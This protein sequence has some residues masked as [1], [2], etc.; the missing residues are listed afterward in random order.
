[1]AYGSYLRYGGP[2]EVRGVNAEKK[3]FFLVD[4]ERHER[5]ADA[6][7]VADVARTIFD[8]HIVVWDCGEKKVSSYD[9]RKM[10]SRRS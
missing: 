1:M 2:F 3:T 8:C 6:C 4:K 7:L 5:F 9:T 10:T